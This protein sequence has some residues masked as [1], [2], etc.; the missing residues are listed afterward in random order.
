MFTTCSP[1]KCSEQRSHD[2]IYVDTNKQM[3]IN[4]IL[5]QAIET[6]ALFACLMSR[7]ISANKQRFSLK[8]NQRTVLSAMAFQRSERGQNGKGILKYR[9]CRYGGVK[10]AR[11]ITTGFK[12]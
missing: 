5:H 1:S 2:H 7:T 12:A 10:N 6:K 9:T 11:I 8:I 4:K 3:K